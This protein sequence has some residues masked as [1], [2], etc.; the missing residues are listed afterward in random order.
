MGWRA[1]KMARA[2][3][4][5]GRCCPAVGFIAPLFRVGFAFGRCAWRRLRLPITRLASGLIL[6]VAFGGPFALSVRRFGLRVDFKLGHLTTGCVRTRR[7]KRLIAFDNYAKRAKTHETTISDE[8]AYTQGTYVEGISGCRRNARAVFDKT[9]S[10][11][12]V[13]PRSLLVLG[14][15]FG[16]CLLDEQFAACCAGSA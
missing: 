7:F 13:G 6:D 15:A 4:R 11:L 10:R 16:G 9:A 3:C 2:M 8:T 1:I 12:I 5:F 14:V